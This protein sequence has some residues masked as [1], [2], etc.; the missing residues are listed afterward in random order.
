MLKTIDRIYFNFRNILR[1][2]DELWQ[3]GYTA[4]VEANHAALLAKLSQK[5]IQGFS[6][7]SLALGYS[8]AVS[9][10]KGEVK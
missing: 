5:S 10:V 3:E 4:G 7:P 9:V 6:D 2:P 8:H 1:D